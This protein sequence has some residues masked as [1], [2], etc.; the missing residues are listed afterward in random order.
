MNHYVLVLTL[1]AGI[2]SLIQV[3]LWVHGCRNV[4]RSGIKSRGRTPQCGA[5]NKHIATAIEKL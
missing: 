5:D 3:T 1:H 4:L 2:S